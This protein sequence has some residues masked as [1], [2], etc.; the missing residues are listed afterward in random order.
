M[1]KA[2][3]ERQTVTKRNTERRIAARPDNSIIPLECLGL[4]VLGVTLIIVGF[5][6]RWLV[7]PYPMIWG[8]I[9]AI[10]VVLSIVRLLMVHKARRRARDQIA[11]PGPQRF[12]VLVKSEQFEA[13]L[14]TLQAKAPQLLTREITERI[15]ALHDELGRVPFG[16]AREQI[17]PEADGSGERLWFKVTKLE[18]GKTSLVLRAAAEEIAPLLEDA[19]PPA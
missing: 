4:F 15:K 10:M 16:E 8:A 7:F 13:R 19:K 17:Y 6:A 12:P 18:N 3:R 5:I 14:G 9:G 1:G 2:R 11:E